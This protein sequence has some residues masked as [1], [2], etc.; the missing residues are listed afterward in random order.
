MRYTL[1]VLLCLALAGLQMSCKLPGSKQ[2]TGK[3]LDLSKDEAKF[4]YALGLEIG[5]SLK[6]ISEKTKIDTDILTRAIQDQLS[7][8]KPQLSDSAALAI[9]KQVFTQ[10]QQQEGEKM[11]KSAKTN[12]ADEEAFLKKNK[13]KAGVIT[14]ASGLQYEV[15]KKGTG[16]SPKPTDPVTVHY[17]G[18]LL[19]GTEFDSSYKRGEPATFQVN[20]VIPGWS[21]ALQLM[22]VGGKYKLYIP[23]KLAYGQQGAGGK[24]GPN[25]MLIFEVELISIGAPEV[26]LP[27]P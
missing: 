13:T 23:S 12:Q 27:R 10:M 5:A 26:K 2:Q 17:K 15:L 7:G 11:A 25:A 14:T 24:I 6:Q 19:D 9:K 21:E 22:N 1:I 16:K 3:A 20:Q 8:A 4:S 18:T